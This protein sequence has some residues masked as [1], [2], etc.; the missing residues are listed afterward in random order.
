VDAHRIRR[1][2]ETLV[3]SQVR[4]GRSSSDP[5]SWFGRPFI[6]VVYDLLALLVGIGAAAAIVPSLG[7]DRAALAAAVDSAAPFL[8]LVGVAAVL[9]AGVMF[10]LTTSAKFTGSDAANWLPITSTEYVAA[11]STAIAYTYSPAIALFLGALLPVA[12]AGGVLPIYA[13]AAAL[14]VVALYEGAIL[15]EMVR[16]AT[17]L[18]GSASAGRRGHVTILVR[19]AALVVLLLAFNL[20]F[21]PVYLLAF[22]ER[23]GSSGLWTAAVPIFWSTQALADLIGGRVALGLA[24]AIAQLG[25][26]ALLAYLAGWLRARY[27]VPSPSEIAVAGAAPALG[28]PFLEALGL[29][30]AEA[31]IVS[32]DLRGIVRRREM[33]PTLVVPVVLI[34]LLVVEGGSFGRLGSALWA[35]WVAGFF[36]LLLASRALGQERRSLQWLYAYPLSVGNLL[37]A[38]AASVMLPALAGAVAVTLVVGVLA[39]LS[40]LSDAGLLLVLL[41][42]SVVLTLWGLVFAARYSDFQD[43]PRP[44]FIRQGPMLAAMGSGMVLLL[45]ILVPGSIAILSPSAASLALGAWAAAFAIGVGALSLYWARSGFDELFRE[46]PS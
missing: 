28:H 10:E 19:A 38:K 21:N 26:V 39:G 1:L 6:I 36:A 45:V 30:R 44:Q 9:L 13:L 41:A 25:F 34:V 22:L 31:A 4:T 14:A 35:G 29:T 15:V 18:S 43:R 24:F 8:P 3:A 7:L 33:M 11:S 42:G 16:A 17:Q 12:I 27:W 40:P 37:R 5:T 2:A 46:L 32:K 20:A 23:F